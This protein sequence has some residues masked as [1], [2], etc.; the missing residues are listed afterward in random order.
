MSEDRPAHTA[1]EGTV[2]ADDG[3]IEVTAEMVAA[4]RRVIYD[5]GKWSVSEH[6]RYHGLG[7]GSDD[8]IFKNAI[9]AALSAQPSSL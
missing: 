3:E 5:S 4:L 7:P 1:P 8:E 9:R 2:S 6:L